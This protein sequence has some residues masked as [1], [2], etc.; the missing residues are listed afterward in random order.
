MRERIKS[1]LNSSLSSFANF[2][3]SVPVALY[4]GIFLFSVDFANRSRYIF[5]AAFI[6]SVRTSS[7]FLNAPNI[8]LTE[9]CGKCACGQSV[10]SVFANDFNGGG[11]YFFFREQKLRRHILLPKLKIMLRNLCY[12][13]Y[14]TIRQS[15]CQERPH[16]Q[17][18][19]K[20]KFEKPTKK[21]AGFQNNFDY[22]Y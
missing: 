10:R 9:F 4:G 6:T 2:I 1:S 15:F 21:T 3:Y 12:Q 22:D 11:Y 8:G 14:Y 17:V 20:K 16:M 19:L 18:K 7:I 13:T 5:S